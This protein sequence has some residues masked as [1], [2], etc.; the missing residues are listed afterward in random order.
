MKT[1]AILY[2]IRLGD[3]KRARRNQNRFSSNWI[4]TLTTAVCS[5]APVCKPSLFASGSGVVLQTGTRA[6]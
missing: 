4:G 5:P 1:R 6:G 2:F 3:A